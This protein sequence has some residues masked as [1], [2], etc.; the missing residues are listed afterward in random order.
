M[1]ARNFKDEIV[2]ANFCA[3]DNKTLFHILSTRSES[4]GNGE[5]SL[6]IWEAIKHAAMKGLT[7]DFAGLGTHGSI[8]LYAGFGATVSPRDVAVRATGFARLAAE[9][10]CLLTK[11]NFLF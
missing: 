9:V 10:K 3:W 5:V 2:A 11:E 6:L 4:A 8:L 1:A 7:F